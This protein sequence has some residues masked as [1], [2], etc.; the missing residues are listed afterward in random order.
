M[1]HPTV[2]F[3]MLALINLA[4][5]TLLL[6]VVEG[7]VIKWSES[8]IIEDNLKFK[9]FHGIFVLCYRSLYVIKVITINHI[10]KT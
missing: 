9:M 2:W 10:F 1:A 3:K 5:N 8:I 7:Y 6:I 4:E